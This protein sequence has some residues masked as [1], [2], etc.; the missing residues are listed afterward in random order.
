[1]E[2]VYA[3]GQSDKRAH[4]LLSVHLLR[5]G[6]LITKSVFVSI[7]CV[8]HSSK[9]HEVGLVHGRLPSLGSNI[10][11]LPEV[12]FAITRRIKRSESVAVSLKDFC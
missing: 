7:S 3:L 1:M 8:G 5:Y 11:H 2:V 10:P 6:A 9:N 12:D 4:F